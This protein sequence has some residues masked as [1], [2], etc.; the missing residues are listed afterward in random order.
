MAN[1]SNT[2]WLKDGLGGSQDDKGVI[3]HSESV[4]IVFDDFVTDMVQAISDSGFRGGQVHR[5]ND[6]LL[7]QSNI[8]ASV[9]ED[10]NAKVWLFELEYS[11][12]GF[13]ESAQ[14]DETYRPS[15][16][17]GRWSYPRTV[18]RDKITDKPILL[19]TGEPYESAFIEQ[20]S[21]PILS[22]TIKEYSANVDRIAM[23]GSVNNTQIKIAGIICPK[24]CA[25]LDD[26][27][28]KPHYDEEGYL[29]FENTFKIK[30]KFF[31]NKSGDEIGFKLESLAAS[32]NEIGDDGE[33]DAI[34]VKNPEY[35]TDRKK[36]ILAAT[37]QMVGADGKK[38]TTPYYQEWMPFDSVS[39]SQ[40]G[41]PSSYTVS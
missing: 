28:P 39:F 35:P 33:L 23:I 37:P 30:L 18:T 25:M 24:Y 32:F 26:Y 40:F 12:R 31:K 10:D 5:S 29:T 41:L 19:P 15:V 8:T 4:I 34:M 16:D 21:A 9:H 2:K 11:T 22:I 7:L 13:N 3:T 6:F 17:I 38:T 1:V 36:D 14:D 20:I 27:I